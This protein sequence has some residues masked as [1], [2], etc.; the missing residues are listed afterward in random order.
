MICLYLCN[1][2]IHQNM[3]SLDFPN[4]VFQLSNCICLNWFFLFQLFT[5]VGRRSFQAIMVQQFILL[6]VL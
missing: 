6:V 4:C 3:L 1:V 5:I 2:K